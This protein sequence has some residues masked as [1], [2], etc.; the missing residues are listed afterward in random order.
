MRSPSLIAKVP[1]RRDPIPCV[2]FQMDIPV[3]LSLALDGKELISIRVS[4]TQRERS[5]FPMAA[6]QRPGCIG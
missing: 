3:S 2:V 4:L 1:G 5:F 6:R